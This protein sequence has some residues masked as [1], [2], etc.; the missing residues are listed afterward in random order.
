MLSSLP[1][2]LLAARAAAGRLD[3]FEELLLRYRDRVY[4]ICHRSA[5]N[6]EDA[7]DWA[8]EC[9]LRAY[10]QLGHYNPARPFAPWLL[11][12]AANT[13]INLAKSRARSRER[14]E[15]ELREET[16]A[17]R[18]DQANSPA[19]DPLDEVLS[20][21]ATRAI[22]TALEALAPALREA[23]VLRVVGELS[24]REL[25]EAL[26]VPLQTAAARV[27]RAVMQVRQQLAG[28]E[29]GVGS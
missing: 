8:Q 13:C 25:A 9:L 23:I 27:R 26:G 2:E 16:R 18:V 14:L 20:G 22:V 11:R 6:A 10:R 29:I 17:C 12:L 4:R 15:V 3:C 1:D 24:Y 19:L 28:S 21:E 5:G 7:E